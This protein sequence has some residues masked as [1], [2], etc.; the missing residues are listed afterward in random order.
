[1]ADDMLTRGCAW[2]Y[3]PFLVSLDGGVEDHSIPAEFVSVPYATLW[4]LIG[5]SG[6]GV[7]TVAPIADPPGAGGF[8]FGF[9]YDIA[10]P[11]CPTGKTLTLNAREYATRAFRDSALHSAAGAAVFG[12]GRWIL[13][14]NGV[15]RTLLAQLTSSMVAAGA[16]VLEPAP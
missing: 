6:A 16:A 3:A 14:V 5:K 7:C 9:A 12:M 8:V 13:Q 4:S 10:P 11:A 2:P 1:M 15:D